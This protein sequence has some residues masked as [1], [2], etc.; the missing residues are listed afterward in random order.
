MPTLNERIDTSLPIDDAFDF[1]ADFANSSQW[2]PGV[3]TSERVDGDLVGVGSRYRLGVRMRGRVAPMEYRTTVFDPPSRV[4]LEGRG[5]GVAAVDD[6]TFA[7]TE[8]G[9]RIGYVAHIRLTGAMRLVAPFAGGTFA[10]IARDARDGMQRTLDE[11]AAARRAV[12]ASQPAPNDE[13]APAVEPVLAEG[14]AR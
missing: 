1:V 3:A 13:P 7:S 8:S 10:R 11:R 14:G 12:S 5:S 6:I 2:D 9:T 4:V